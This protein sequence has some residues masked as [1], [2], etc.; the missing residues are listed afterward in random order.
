MPRATERVPT[1]ANPPRTPG[2][3][4]DVAMSPTAVLLKPNPTSA[5]R[6]EWEL[7]PLRPLDVEAARCRNGASISVGSR[8]G[9]TGSGALTHRSRLRTVRGHARNRSPRGRRSNP[10]KG[11]WRQCGRRVS[12]HAGRVLL[13][14]VSS[15]I[16]RARPLDYAAVPARCKIRDRPAP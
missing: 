6:L 13:R 2:L 15:L 7:W 10:R 5:P 12:L 1:D 16:Q 14:N 11:R 8:T 9:R 4:S 3:M